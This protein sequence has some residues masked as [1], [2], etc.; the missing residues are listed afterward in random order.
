MLY[1]PLILSFNRLHAGQELVRQFFTAFRQQ[2]R[3]KGLQFFSAAVAI[4]GTG[5]IQPAISSTAHII[6]A[7][8]HHQHPLALYTGLGENIAHHFRFDPGSHPWT[9]R[10]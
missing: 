8:A 7:V 1:S 6:V 4:Q 9:R 2:H 5:G 3:A 10:R